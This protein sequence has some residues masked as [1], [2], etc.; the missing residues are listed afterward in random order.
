M[1][2][3]GF[4]TV[5]VG[6]SHQIKLYW[7]IDSALIY[8]MNYRPP[9]FRY[10]NHIKFSCRILH[11]L[12]SNLINIVFLSF[13]WYIILDHLS[14]FPHFCHDVFTPLSYISLAAF[15]IFS[16]T[17]THDNLCIPASSIVHGKER[18]LTQVYLETKQVNKSMILDFWTY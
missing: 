10:P 7:P 13:I 6:A 4:L 15:G 3:M 11:D 2:W 1:L 9:A 17:W 16:K 5:V 14:S 12:M 18:C 8:N